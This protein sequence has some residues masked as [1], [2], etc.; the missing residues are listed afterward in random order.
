MKRLFTISALLFASLL[1]TVASGYTQTRT[2][3][4]SPVPL[5]PELAN[6]PTITAELWVQ[7]DPS[8][9]MTLEGPSFDRQ[10][11][12]YAT[13]VRNPGQVSKITRKNR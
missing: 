3:D 6:L 1:L 2:V 10:G 12:L 4:K 5:P 9:T 13:G 11:N 7:V 8:T